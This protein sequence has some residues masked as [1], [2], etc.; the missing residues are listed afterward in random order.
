MG[1]HEDLRQLAEQFKKRMPVIKGE[2]AT[3]QALV[4]PFLQTLGYDIYDPSVVQPEFIADFAKKRPGGPMEKVDYALHKG[5]QI[6]IFLECKALGA[7]LDNHDPQL[8]R[9]FN[10]ITSAKLAVITDGVRWRF[11]TDLTAPNVM[12]ATPFFSFDVLRFSEREAEHLSQFTFANFNVGTVQTYAQDLLFLERVTASVG[13]LLRNPSEA[14]VRFMLSELDIVQ[15]K[16][17]SRVVEKAMPVVRKAIQSTLIDMMTKSITQEMGPTPSAPDAAPITAPSVQVAA[18]PRSQDTPPMSLEP[19]TKVETTG[20]EL[21]IFNLV[22]KMCSDTGIGT[23]IAYKDTVSYL[24]INLGKVRRWF[25]RVLTNGPRRNI[26]FRMT[27][28][29]A[30]R[31]GARSDIEVM[32][33][34]NVR[35]YFQHPSDLWNLKPVITLAYELETK[36]KDTEAVEEAT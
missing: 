20:E 14:F 4:M 5:G 6:A 23:P 22:S 32:S 24:G 9:Y 11:F 36:R 12:D 34:G 3:K 17:T 29:Q 30:A 35:A 1:L 31:L 28:E 25:M 21:E 13:D 19:A 18:A 8:A 26:V 33:D 7:P 2:E 16:V 15:G 27:A 10:A